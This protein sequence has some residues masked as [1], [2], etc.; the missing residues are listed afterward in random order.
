[1]KGI[2][3][4][5]III[6]ALNEEQGIAFVIQSIPKEELARGG[7]KTE[8]I[9]VD[10]D[11]DDDTTRIAR[12]NDAR[13][14]FEKKRGY[15]YACKKGM[16][17]SNGEIIVLCDAD[18]TYPLRDLP[19][20]LS[21][22]NER[23]LDFLVTNRFPRGY[24]NLVT[25]PRM[26]RLG[27]AFLSTATRLLFGISLID[28]QSGMWI[29]DV[30]I[31]RKLIIRSNNMPFSQEIKIDCIFFQN[32]KWDQISIKYGNRIGIKKLNNIR[33]G[34]HNLFSLFVKRLYR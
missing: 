7:Y 19:R 17:E 9:V 22:Y 11:S 31:A 32:A 23:Q 1:M 2:K 8:I 29:V 15:G 6:P 18:N 16:Q 25:M 34:I 10:N 3:T 21:Y 20:L 5:S 26:N 28:S 30:A 33:D 14:V 12:R 24:F 27:N 4:L 13:V